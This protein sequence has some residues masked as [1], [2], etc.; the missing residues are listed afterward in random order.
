MLVI[1][2]CVIGLSLGS[3]CSTL[4]ERSIVNKILL[5]L[6]VL[7]LPGTGHF[8]PS[9]SVCSDSASINRSLKEL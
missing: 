3:S 4:E 6:M 8:S 9:I 7:I 5:R 2:C 1:K